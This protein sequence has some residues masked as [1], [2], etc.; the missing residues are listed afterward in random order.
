MPLDSLPLV[1]VIII[2]YNT[3]RMTLDCLA[4]LFADLKSIDADVWVVDN[5]SKDGS[6]D[7]VRAAFP[8]VHLIENPNNAGFGAANNLALK[9]AAGEYLLLLNS[10][11]FV[12][13]GAVA[14]LVA[15]L[16]SHPEAGIVGPRLLNSDGSRQLSC[17]RFPSPKR[18]WLENLGL[19]G[20]LARHPV[21]G[22]Y[23]SWAHD[24]EKSVEW[25]IGACLLVRREAYIQAGSF[26]EVFFMYQEETD[27]QRRVR[28]CGWD[29]ALTPAAIVTHLGGASGASQ[30]EK[31]NAH[32][33]DS[34]DYYIRKHHGLAG[35]ISLRLAMIIGSAVR[36][37]AWSGVAAMMPRR[38]TM[39]QSKKRLQAWLCARQA[40]QWRG[41]GKGARA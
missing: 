39:A 14:A 8:Q 6:A 28:D 30:Q 25:V 3:C 17:Y 10:D 16:K 5:A 13:P 11:A 18:A 7:A 23:Q 22:D 19:T 32:F 36:V 9:S 33:F 20:L 2:S 27:W 29:I 31:I 41:A 24:T 12:Q 15:Y 1:S 35:L 40:T 4:A 37:L 21:L 34:L 26:D 38:R